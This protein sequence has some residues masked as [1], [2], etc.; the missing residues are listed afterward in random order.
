MKHFALFWLILTAI[1]AF[2]QD[3]AAYLQKNNL[4]Y[5]TGRQTDYMKERCVLDVYYPVK[6]ANAPVI[7]WFHGGGITGGNKSIP[8]ELKRQNVIVIAAN[9]RLSPKVSCPA[10]IEDAAAAVAWAFRNAASFGGDSNKIYV[11]GHS[12]GA[13]LS[14]MVGL[15]K[16]WLAPYNIDAD[17]IA[18]IF[19]FSAQAITHFTVRKE[20][21]I[22]DT[23]PVIDEFAPLYHVR[24]DAPPLYL[25]TGN[26]EMEMLGRYEEN[27][28]LA[29]MMQ[30]TGHKKTY[31]YEM[32]GY[33]H[34]DMPKPSFYLM[35]KEIN[36]K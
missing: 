25:Y 21:G 12:A 5:R 31:L 2:S 7:V 16:K 32:D 36:K 30:L 14:C 6:A 33:G 1:P 3:T 20:R 13:Y 34:G 26:R 18:A 8:A 35:L 23:Q 19:S 29:R 28:Y 17:R 22:A 15:D 4:A 10:Y 24:A 9:Y 11:S 27:A